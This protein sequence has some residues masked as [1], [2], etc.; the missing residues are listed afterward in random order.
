MTIIGLFYLLLIVGWILLILVLKCKRARAK[1]LA[2]EQAAAAAAQCHII[3]IGS[4]YY[5]I[6][7]SNHPFTANSYRSCST[8]HLDETNGLNNNRVSEEIHTNPAFIIHDEGGVFPTT[9]T[10]PDLPPSYDEVIR[11]P[12]SYPKVAPRLSAQPPPEA[13]RYEGPAVIS[14]TNI[15]DQRIDTNNNSNNTCTCNHSNNNN[16][17]I[18]VSV[19]RQSDTV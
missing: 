3:Q 12:N 9:G 19:R 6:V 18:P 5:D 7:P 10:L 2:E 11:L 13:P 17:N 8:L 16:N 4:N 15:D 1:R 14:V